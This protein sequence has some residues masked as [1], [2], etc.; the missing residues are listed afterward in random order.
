MQ[1]KRLA[2]V[3]GV[4]AG[5][6]VLIAGAIAATRPFATTSARGPRPPIRLKGPARTSTS[7]VATFRWSHADT[8][9]SGFRCRLDRG[10]FTRCKSGITYKQ[11]RPGAHTFTLIALDAA[12]RRSAAAKG[13]T[14]SS[15]PSW[16]WTVA[17][18]RSTPGTVPSPPNPG[19]APVK[20]NQTIAFTK[21]T[22][23]SFGEGS[24]TLTASASSGLQVSF[25]SKTTSVCMTSGPNGEKVN[26][27]ATGTC[28]IEAT[29]AGNANWNTAPAVE[30]SFTVAQG[31]Q[32]IAFAKPA[33]KSF[34]EGSTT[35]EATATSGLPVG[36]ES[37]TTSVC[38]TS[39]IAGE[40]VT[41][42]ANGTCT[43]KA[44]QA[45]NSNW[46]AAPAVE[47][48]FAIGKG[49]Q[50]VTFNKPADKSFSEGSTTVGATATSGL[51]VDF[52]SQ[53]TGVCTVAGPSGEKVTFVAAG[54]CTIE[55]T[56]A[57]DSDWGAATPATQSFTITKGNQTIAF[58]APTEKRLDQGPVTVTATATSGLAVTF[59]SKTVSVCT[60]SGA[61]GTTVTL[62]TTGTCTIA[63]NQGGEANWNAAA[64]VEQSFTVAKG[65]QTIA[66]E[67]LPAG[68]RLDEGPITVKAKATSGLPV[69]F[70]SQTAGVCTTS[71]TSGEKVS[72]VA[73][74]T[75]T[76]KASQT[77]SSEWNQ[78]TEEQSFTVAKGNQ[79]IAFT[80]PSSASFNEGSTTVEA[81]A[82]SGL[83]VTFESETTGICT[84]SGTSGENITFHNA[85][86][87]TIKATQAGNSNW[88][89]ATAVEQSFT[90][91]KGN[92]T[93]A[94][95][96]LPGKSFGEGSTIVAATA[97]SGL[98][99]TFES[100]TTS[101][102]TVSGSGGEKVSLV[103]AGT[104]TIKANQSG[105]SNWNAATSIEQSFTIAKGNQTITFNAPAEKRLDQSP[106]TA[107]A[108]ASSGLSV[109][110]NSK[111][112]G[113]CTTSGTLGETVT[114]HAA[115]TCTLE[116]TQ[117][118]NSNWNVAPP[119]EQSFTVAK[120]NQT[121]AFN[122]PTEKR[123]DQGPVTVEAS[124]SSG[125]AVSFESKT[126]S[127][128]T[129]SGTS[130]EIVTF[131]TKGTCTI[132][133]T[134]G[135]D[136]NWN[137]APAVERSFTIAKG[138]QTIA[139]E[140]LPASKRLDE[141]PI[142]LKAKASSGLAVTFESKTISACTTSGA[143]GETV[144][145]HTTGTCT[146][147]ASQAGSS[148]WNAAAEEQGLTITKG[149][150]TITF[151]EPPSKS[152]SEGS[153]T[154]TA[155][156]SSG[157]AVTF[158]SKT[159]SICTVSGSG[160][161]KVNFLT[162]G[163]CTIKATQAGGSEWNAATP[164]EQ[165]FTIA[166]S[167]QTITFNEPTEK[168][169][170]QGPITVEATATSGLP[171]GFESK[172][173]SVCT[174]SGTLGEK[175]NFLT[176]GPCTIKATQTGNGNWNPATAVERSFTVAKGNQTITF[177]APAEKRLDQS[178]IAVTATATSGLAISFNSKTT[179]V[180]TTSGTLGETVTLHTVGT[181]TIEATQ[182]GNTSWNP[183][184]AVSQS[185]TI[186]KGNQT[187]TFN[188]P[189][190]K[191]FSEGSATLTATAS[192]GLAVT[193]ESKTTSICTVSG[194][195]GEKVSFVTTG[196]CTIKASQIGS[197]NWNAATPVER[198]FAITSAA[199]TL[200]AL[201][202]PTVAAGEGTSRVVV[203]LDGK[204]VY[205]T[206]RG[207]GGET[208]SQYSRNAET[209]KLTALVPATVPTGIEPEDIVVSPDGANVY[210]ANRGSNTVSR[211]SRNGTSGALT[212]QTT[213]A[214]GG[215]PIGLAITPD[216]KQVY[217][218]NSTSAT[219]SQFSRNTGTGELKALVTA[220][221]AAGAN[222]HGIDVSP[223]GK[224]VYVANYGADTLSEYARNE[225][226]GELTVLG[227]VT[228]GSNPHDLDISPDG[229]SVYVADSTSPGEVLE[230]SRN[231]ETGL[232]T[233][234]AAIVA[235]EFT[236]CIVVSPD[237]SSVYVTNEVTNNV[238]QYSRNTETGE[239]TALTP[240]AIATGLA[241]EGIDVSPDSKNVYVAN[242]ESG[243]V[244]QYSR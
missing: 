174:T 97:S 173:T 12:G 194:A 227:T 159:T 187:I 152:F 205:A 200:T 151:G 21:P 167:N 193:F 100:K 109:S 41:F 101:I 244:S 210:V 243:S 142:T 108:T 201:S 6:G 225:V 177:N 94:F 163:T 208:V 139:F 53:T 204:N 178:P 219:V 127:V 155:T 71:G 157:L 37:K 119:V 31:N 40:T 87:C 232:L 118:G 128:C 235:G 16:S 234:Q 176:A 3:L 175:V 137:A 158:E 233:E 73:A 191:L 93:I 61:T 211:Y 44:T 228:G 78:T 186:A 226:S 115:G 192:S 132:K 26:F 133:T 169:L 45:G 77:G 88:N 162:A 240:A 217:A 123:L 49:T 89:A 121:I 242:H 146:I 104:C 90:I 43:I 36:F 11:L 153:T 120:G 29:Q 103:A 124:A 98:A 199:T 82:A 27:L 170:D 214:T 161:E 99:V 72:F 189:P 185:F 96:E 223:D 112:T 64:P 17:K 206:N 46:N 91:T 130:G 42:L 63:A 34:S 4:L 168:R 24:T 180:C 184:T 14:K 102:C 203:S 190:G 5:A 35:I 215:G 52:N 62:H 147:K 66:F 220:T 125:L 95:A 196:T 138:N 231:A 213:V 171:V 212:V 237:G 56:Q 221:V 160:G 182:S 107:T 32:T 148:E 216:G 164:V 18:A 105:S 67:G 39:G 238:S 13:N 209:G 65:N 154:L 75:C 183:A 15:P 48:S 83:I 85:G 135:G 25:S 236:E 224:N 50:T 113:V 28:T 229:A 202:P 2:I 86:T 172:T 145:F 126:T 198:S 230:M 68:K 8:R 141:G 156:A 55:A 111:T 7:Q 188:E 59:E 166:K 136:P 38:A 22:D 117:S 80:K 207:G 74:G 19:A 81:T 110:L 106:V 239:L 20:D 134:Q 179:G 150:Q 165:S 122:A 84:T 149:N 58:N 51:A 1:M 195:N 241:P 129:T 79:T 114:F 9:T 76:I 143:S 69:T 57:G 197:A 60:T 54:T 140:G 131:N 70:E 116:A 144:T 33:N 10:R 92:Q 30:R 23:K 181:C 47:Q 222:A 218:A